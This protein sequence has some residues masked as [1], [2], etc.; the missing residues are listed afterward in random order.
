MDLVHESAVIDYG[1]DDPLIDL[2]VLFLTTNND[3]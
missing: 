1:F 2:P 3:D